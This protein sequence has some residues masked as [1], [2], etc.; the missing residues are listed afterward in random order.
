LY[1]YNFG[2]LWQLGLT[3]RRCPDYRADSSGELWELQNCRN[4]LKN[5]M[6]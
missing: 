4:S 6:L 1:E 2:D 3:R 5:R